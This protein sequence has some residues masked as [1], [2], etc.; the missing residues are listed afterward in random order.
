MKVPDCSDLVLGS[1]YL[2]PWLP[3][4]GSCCL[5]S[6]LV[7]WTWFHGCLEKVPGC[8]DM[9]TGFLDLIHG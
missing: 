1:L 5:G 6:L 7:P 8:W 2:V 9:V 3:G 4:E